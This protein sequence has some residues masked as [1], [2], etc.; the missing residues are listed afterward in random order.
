MPLEAASC[1]DFSIRTT[2]LLP[3]LTSS[4]GVC[5]TNPIIFYITSAVHYTFHFD[6]SGYTSVRQL[7]M[8]IRPTS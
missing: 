3:E 2:F 6:P 4:L 5:L 7:P 8:Y 1:Y